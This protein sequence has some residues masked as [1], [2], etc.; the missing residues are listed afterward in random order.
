MYELTEEQRARLDND[1]THHPPIG[2]QSLRYAEI[3]RSQR[4]LAET[5][6]RCTPVSRE[7]SAAL[8]LLD[9]VGMMAN[10]AIARNEKE[11]RFGEDKPSPAR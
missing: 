1:Y 10:A 8:T 5:I 6:M 3:R 7:Q 2:D 4:A 9:Q 11:E